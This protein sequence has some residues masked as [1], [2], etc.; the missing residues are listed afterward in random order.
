M[1]DKATEA[2]AHVAT[3]LRTE[4]CH[5]R[6]SNFRFRFPSVQLPIP[7]FQLPIT[8]F[9]FRMSSFH[10]PY[11]LWNVG[12]RG[13]YLLEM[14]IQPIMLFNINDLQILNFILSR[15]N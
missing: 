3:K 11:P 2:Q 13:S 10:F 6:F 8:N 1:R 9:H 4:A 12:F 14:R 5:F 7:N 15:K